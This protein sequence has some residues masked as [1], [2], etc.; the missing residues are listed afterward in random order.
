ML[1]LKA[2]I[3][4]REIFKI[5]ELKFNSMMLKRFRFQKLLT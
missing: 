5:I 2:Q 4:G 1:N 3:K